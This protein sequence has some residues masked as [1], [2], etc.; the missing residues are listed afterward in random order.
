MHPQRLTPNLRQL[1]RLLNGTGPGSV[2]QIAQTARREADSGLVLGLKEAER[3]EPQRE[4]R[5]CAPGTRRVE[6]EQ[7]HQDDR[8]DTEGD[9]A[10]SSPLRL[11][12]RSNV[13]NHCASVGF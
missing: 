10:E 2:V 5:D 6:H 7:E 1:G 12:A 11:P 3:T 4:E 13:R 8:R 9:V